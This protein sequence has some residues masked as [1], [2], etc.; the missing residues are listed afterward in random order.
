MASLCLFSLHA[1]W[2][3]GCTGAG[4]GVLQGKASRRNLGMTRQA[5][6]ALKIPAG[7]PMMGAQPMQQGNFTNAFGQMPYGGSPMGTIPA[8][9]MQYAPQH[10][11]FAGQ[12]QMMPGKY[13]ALP[14]VGYPAMPNAMQSGTHAGMHGGMHMG[15]TSRQHR[16]ARM[17]A[18]QTNYMQQGGAAYAPALPMAHAAHQPAGYHPQAMQGMNYPAMQQHADAV[19]QFQMQQYQQMEA[20]VM[21]QVQQKQEH[22]LLKYGNFENAQYRQQDMQSRPEFRTY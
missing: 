2:T 22:A 19:Q 12:A 5:G 4:A 6:S 17:P 8:F 20:S 16:K 13:G 9:P 14:P 7:N 1:K 15:N 3:V 11:A 18:G 21:H 10:G